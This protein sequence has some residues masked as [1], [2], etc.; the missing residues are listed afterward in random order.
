M[1]GDFA[2]FFNQAAA[3]TVDTIP[4]ITPEQKL[5]AWETILDYCPDDAYE[6][7]QIV[8]IVA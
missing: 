2:S 1:K 3:M 7:G 6:I 4:L 5:N 8:G